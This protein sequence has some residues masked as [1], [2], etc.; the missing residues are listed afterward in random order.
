M[1]LNYTLLL[2]AN[3]IENTYIFGYFRDERTHHLKRLPLFNDIKNK[4]M[5]SVFILFFATFYLVACSNTQPE[6]S[7]IHADHEL[8]ER[9]HDSIEMEQQA[10][11]KDYLLLKGDYDSLKL[12]KTKQ[13]DSL[14]QLE[15]SLLHEDEE[16]VKKDELLMTEDKKL[17]EEKLSATAIQTKH[18]VFKK[19]HDQLIERHKK[20]TLQEQ[21]I[22]KR[23]KVTLDSLRRSPL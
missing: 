9:Q 22:F 3:R 10:L 19:E 15:D 1:Y 12:L 7:I 20:I 2:F 16:I 14:F 6:E 11:N 8:M 21:V 17:E 5:K 18:Q 13:I 4:T 23:L